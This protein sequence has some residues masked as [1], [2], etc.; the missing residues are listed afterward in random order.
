MKDPYE[1]EEQ[2]LGK[3]KFRK[4]RKLL[5]KTDRSKFKKTDQV[6]KEIKVEEHLLKGQVTAITGEGIWVRYDSQT[7]LCTLKGVLKKDKMLSKN[8]IAVG[9]FAFFEKTSDAEGSISHVAERFSSLARTDITGKKEQLIAANIDQVFLV[10]SCLDPPLKPSLI[11]RYLIAAKKGDLHPIIVINKVDLLEKDT[12]EMEIYREFLLAYEPLGYPI[13][14]ISTVTGQGIEAFKSLMKDKVSVISGQSGVGKSSILNAAFHLGRRIGELAVK[15]S[16]GAHTTTTAEMIDLPGGGFCIDTPGIRSFGIW[17][18]E[19]EEV[20]DHFI[21]ISQIGKKC[22]YSDCTHM[23]EPNCAVL[24]ALKEDKIPL[25]RYESY[26]TL[27]NES[28]KKGDHWSKQ[29]ELR[30]G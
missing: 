18:L 19:K 22:R 28:M 8:L 20:R 27:L 4:E 26:C 16:K 10:V 9:D 21:D 29:K 6:K 30:N 2:Y 25:M 1:F 7:F 3:E 5:Q 13:L 11:D 17:N 14:S 23:Q 15:T 24:A 12:S